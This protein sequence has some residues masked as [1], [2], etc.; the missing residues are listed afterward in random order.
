MNSSVT[1]QMISPCTPGP[2]NHSNEWLRQKTNCLKE[3]TL[4]QL[5]EL[6]EAIG[7][8]RSSFSEAFATEAKATEAKEATED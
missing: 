1:V 4:K 3:D 5:Y 7:N 6:E 2:G 8:L